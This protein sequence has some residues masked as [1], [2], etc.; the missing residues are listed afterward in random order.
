MKKIMDPLTELFD[1]IILS[2]VSSKLVFTISAFLAVFIRTF[3]QVY[4]ICRHASI[5][6]TCTISQVLSLTCLL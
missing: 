6:A 3:V 4:Y 5:H 2:R 1:I